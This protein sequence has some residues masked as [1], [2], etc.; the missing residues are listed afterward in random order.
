[1]EL[2]PSRSFRREIGTLRSEMN[3]LWNRFFGE[4]SIAARDI[5]WSFSADISENK[6]NYNL[7]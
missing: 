1:M 6:E 5:G 7:D 3:D 2:I 4:T